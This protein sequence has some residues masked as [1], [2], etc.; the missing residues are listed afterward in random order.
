M[1]SNRA[2]RPHLYHLMLQLARRRCEAVERLP[3]LRLGPECAVSGPAAHAVKRP[4]IDAPKNKGRSQPKSN[5]FDQ[6]GLFGT[7]PMGWMPKEK[8]LSVVQ[9]LHQ[10]GLQKQAVLSHAHI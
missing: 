7:P 10:E 6:G 9:A 3:I 4:P 1:S 5:R 2:V 8:I